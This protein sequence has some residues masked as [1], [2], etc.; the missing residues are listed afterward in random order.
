MDKEQDSISVNRRKN[1]VKAIFGK[2]NIYQEL[3]TPAD[4]KHLS[5]IKTSFLFINVFSCN[6]KIYMEIGNLNSKEAHI[7]SRP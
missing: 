3:H 2:K 4:N 6:L 7:L 1:C 5:N